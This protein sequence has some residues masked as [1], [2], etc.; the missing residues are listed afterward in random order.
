[1][2]KRKKTEATEQKN[3]INKGKSNRMGPSAE[4]AHWGLR[5]HRLLY[6]S[7]YT[8]VHHEWCV[9]GMTMGN[10][11]TAIMVTQQDQFYLHAEWTSETNSLH[12]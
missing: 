10:S 2:Y 5:L 6:L 1:M 8:N 11:W 7:M 4:E 12:P 9:K 3:L